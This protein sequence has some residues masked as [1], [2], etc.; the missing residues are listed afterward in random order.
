M[1]SVKK[2]SES[3]SAPIPQNL[4][5]S[6]IF[7]DDVKLNRKKK[8]QRDKSIALKNKIKNMNSNEILELR[9]KTIGY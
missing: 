9:K 7:S 1:D 8:I 2:T 3:T 4:S 5:N 6:S